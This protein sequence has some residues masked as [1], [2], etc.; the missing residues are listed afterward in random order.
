M[1]VEARLASAD[2]RARRPPA[3]GPQPQ[4]PGRDRP[5][6]LPARRVPR[7]RAR[8]PRAARR[9]WS[10]APGSTSTRCCP[11]TPTSSAPSPCASPTTGSPSSRCSG[12]T[13]SASATTRQRLASCAARLRRPGRQHAPPRPRGDRPWSLGLRGPGAQ[14]HGRRGLPR[15]RA[16]VPLR[17]RDRGGAPLAPRSE[18]LVLW[19]SAE[20]GFVEMADAY[21]TGSSADAPEEEP[22][23]PGAG[24]RKDRPRDRQ[25]GWPC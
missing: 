24:A 12:A 14:Q 13:R 22:G 3:H 9:C 7:R 18:E 25:P 8:P 23:R 15:R 16:R 2:R 4:R 19:S 6:A 21:S 5:R 1:N 20:F 11:A 10:T 17:L